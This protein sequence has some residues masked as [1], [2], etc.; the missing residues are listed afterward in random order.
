[1]SQ[2][3]L[4]HV[5]KDITIM[6]QIAQGLE[7]AGYST[8]YF[9]RDVLAGTSYL[10]QITNA[11]ENCD[12]LVLIVS[13]NALDSDQVTKEVVGAFER[14]KP[15]FPVLINIT[16]PGL[17]MSQ[18]EWR[19]A[20][21]GTA[22][23]VVGQGEIP[24]A[25]QR[26]LDGLNA[27]GIMPG[28]VKPPPMASVRLTPSIPAPQN[29]VER[30]LADRSRMEGERKQVTILFAGI[31]GYSSL[32]ERM[33]PEDVH[34]LIRQCIEFMTE[35]IHHYEGTIAQFLGDGL[36]SLFGAPIAHEDDPQ[37]ALYAALAIQHHLKDYSEKL[38]VRNIELAMRI[39][40]NTGIVIVGRIGDDLTMEYTAIG[41]T[42]NLA[43]QI[44][45]T[46]QPG[47]VQVAENTYHLTEAY[48]D[49][50]DLGEMLMNG[51]QQPVRAYRVL[52]PR[53][54]KTRFEASLGKGLTPF[55]GRALELEHLMACLEKVKEGN[56]QIVG[57]MGEPGMGKSRLIR[58]FI[59][60][61]LVNDYSS[62]EGECIHYGDAIPYLPILDIL[63]TYF[64][65]HDEIDERT[66]KQKM[67]DKI[68]EQGK[69]PAS[70]LPPLHEILSLT[71]EDKEHL[72]LEPRLRM[73]K[74]FEAI[75]FLL[76]SRSQKK[77][78]VV[79]MEDMHWIDKTSE[80][81]LSY[82][83][84]GM[85]S[86]RI[87]LVLL[88]RPE[89]NHPWANKTYYS[90]IRVDQLSRKMSSYLVQSILAEG[91]V[92]PEV[93]DLI[94]NK[95]AGNPLFIEE[96]T[97]NLLENR[98][99]EKRDNQYVLCCRPSD[100]LVPDTIQGIIASR[101]DRLEEPLK[102]IIQIASVIGREFAFRILEAV[103][104]LREDLKSSLLTLR[105]LEFIN[106]KTL[107]PELEYTFKHALTREVAYNGLLIKRRRE[108]HEKVGQAIEQT[109]ADRLEEFFE[110][111]AYHYSFSENP[112]KAYQYL[113]LSGNK[114]LKNYSNWEAIRFYKEA[115]SILDKQPETKESKREKLDVCLT[116]IIPLWLMNY[117]EGSLEF[118]REAEQLAK[119]L[120]D[121]RGLTKVYSKLSFYHTVKGNQ[122]LGM[123]YA[124]KCFHAAE[125][126][127]DIDILA[128]TAADICA[129]HWVAC[130]YSKLLDVSRKVLS[131]L[132]KHNREKDFFGRWCSVYS[133]LCGYGGVA[134][135]LLGEL[136]DAETLLT[137]GFRNALE[138][139]DRYGMGW[140]EIWRGYLSFLKG[141]SE[142][143]IDH[144][145]KAIQYFEE[146][147]LGYFLIG[148]CWVLMAFGHYF[149][150]GEV[151][152]AR[153][154]AEKGLKLSKESG[155]PIALPS[156]YWVLFL[157]YFDS[158][159]LVRAR[160]WGGELLRISI[161]LEAKGFGGL[162]LIASGCIEGKSD[163][164]NID[165]ARQRIQQGISKLEECKMKAYSAQGY[166]FLG[167][168]LADVGLRKEARKNLSKAQDL[169]LKMGVSSKFYWPYRV[170][171]AL[172]KLKQASGVKV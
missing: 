92:E 76:I 67:S 53:Q 5:E 154:L 48:F 130:N 126:M 57:V 78:L 133:L 35:E 169:Y 161:E 104:G 81:F 79:V 25:I 123:H 3:F 110:V 102:R 97:R 23:I 153:D 119:E 31:K 49:F 114:A 108:T 8:W 60:S 117:P 43:S 134:L 98:S 140:V 84:G 128:P 109:Y 112:R 172:A 152:V 58:E 120:G 70:M 20:L 156:I 50:E 46:A 101:I 13:P 6:Q 93:I 82:L 44:E 146:V 61:L 121:E 132:V 91:E 141:D 42:V 165:E 63:K 136:G 59:Q 127:G 37:R 106:E 71:I 56:G 87:M 26:I 19:H 66:I 122:S 160:E 111:L 77:P 163:P 166:L 88:Y 18:P 107:F 86:T 131:L 45:S 96:F 69:Y 89:F 150:R 85:A 147:E 7:A 54:V 55:V 103:A 28:G 4:S 83:I 73:E 33:D 14:C 170:E 137:K 65:I 162:G 168:L 12:A 36:M 155:I 95:S 94:V 24:A 167:E 74:V 116:I 72:K 159:D 1:V 17:K 64:D 51:V 40:I 32:S 15:F 125:K 100:I 2:I 27:K 164:K 39:G 80:E 143:L 38:K 171:N 41:D 34:H 158:G 90:Q 68:A 135:S 138:V 113:K 105:D 139:N 115:E 124:E 144:S 47:T 75:R 99:I 145:H 142:T 10:I 62:L 22:M 151:E 129:G 148:P 9:E 30:V 118:F 29:I 157:I 52:N 16:P 11:I 21:G 149:L